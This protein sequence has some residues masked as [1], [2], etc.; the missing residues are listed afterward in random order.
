[1]NH[2]Q[3]TL[4]TVLQRKVDALLAEH[5]SRKPAK[6]GGSTGRSFSMLNNDGSVGTEGLFEQQEPPRHT[7]VVMEK[8]LRRKSLQ[9]RDKQQDWL[10]CSHTCFASYILSW[11]IS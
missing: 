3:V 9:L 10:V 8:I 4:P 2:C 1:M 11:K 5:L 7:S 6:K